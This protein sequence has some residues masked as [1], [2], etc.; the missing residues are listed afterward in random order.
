MGRKAVVNRILTAPTQEIALLRAREAVKK[1]QCSLCGAIDV[2]TRP[3]P[4][5]RKG[6][7][8]ALCAACYDR[9]VERMAKVSDR[10]VSNEAYL[11][12]TYGIDLSDYEDMFIKQD[13][14]CC[15]CRTRGEGKLVVDHNH[16]TGKVRGL[17]CG[18]CNTGIGLL[19]E[20]PAILAAAIVYVTCGD[21]TIRLTAPTMDLRVG[22]GVSR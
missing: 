1:L 2:E 19:G 12:R 22:D 21:R 20:D 16:E 4:N 6:S 8:N 5:A 15:I 13:G 9:L 18:G 3:Y 14:R 10:L 11:R 17:L 7:R